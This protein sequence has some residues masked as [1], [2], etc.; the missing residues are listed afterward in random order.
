MS[1]SSSLDTFKILFIIK[2]VFNVLLG[3]FFSVYIFIGSIIAADI[4]RN[5]MRDVPFNPEAV[6]TL[7]GVIGLVFF[8]FLAVMTFMA[9]K[10]LNDRTGSTFIIIAAC[11]NVFTGL[12]GILLCIFT[13]IELQK[14]HIKAIFNGESPISDSGNTIDQDI[15]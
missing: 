8:I 12:L 4:R 6:I 11:L 14:P 15:I 7:I 13:I 1:K 10:K 3:L 5:E 2:G 9:A